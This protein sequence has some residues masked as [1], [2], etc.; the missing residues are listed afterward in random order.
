MS[1]SQSG[2]QYYTQGIGSAL[3]FFL[4]DV[5]SLPSVPMQPPQEG[6]SH[7]AGYGGFRQMSPYPGNMRAEDGDVRVGSKRGFTGGDGN[8]THETHQEVILRNLSS[9][10]G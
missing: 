5:D 8:E 2:D 6:H 1:Q 10:E 4:R 7:A 9:T 3:E